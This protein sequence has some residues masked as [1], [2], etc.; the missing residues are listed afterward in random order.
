MGSALSAAAMP[1]P[2]MGSLMREAA[3]SPTNSN[4]ARKSKMRVVSSEPGSWDVKPLRVGTSCGDGGEGGLA[5]EWKLPGIS[6]AASDVQ[7]KGIAVGQALLLH[8]LAM[9]RSS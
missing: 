4:S 2:L 9:P 3:G 7:L 5:D 8:S 6:P 1:F